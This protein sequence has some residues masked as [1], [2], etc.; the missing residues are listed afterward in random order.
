MNHRPFEGKKYR[1]DRTGEI[2]TFH[3]EYDSRPYV[4]G[5]KS[6]KGIWDDGKHLTEV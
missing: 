6:G 2:W 4:M 3:L 1:D 5:E